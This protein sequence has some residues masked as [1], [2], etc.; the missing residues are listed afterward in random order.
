MLLRPPTA[1]LLI[2][3]AVA[4]R[5]AALPL[6]AR[7]FS[8]AVAD[9]ELYP[10]PAAKPCPDFSSGPCKKRP[11]WSTDIYKT[12]ALNERATRGRAARR[13]AEAGRGAWTSPSGWCPEHGMRPEA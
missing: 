8:A 7:S 2:N 5:R 11:G 3:T 10:M 1:S 12:A 13:P 6:V 4:G 9:G